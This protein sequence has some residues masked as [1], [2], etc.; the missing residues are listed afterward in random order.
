MAKE[1]MTR[2]RDY[3]RDEDNSRRIRT[4]LA[5]ELSTAFC[6]ADSRGGSVDSHRRPTCP[7]NLIAMG[8][9]LGAGRSD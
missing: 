5:K 4:H 3:A 2:R 1:W 6:I 7:G 9:G 8:G